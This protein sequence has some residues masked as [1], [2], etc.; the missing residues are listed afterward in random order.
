M[1][2]ILNIRRKRIAVFASGNG[3]NLQAIIDH[4]KK[5]DINGDVV[6]ALSNN[7]DAFA[8]KRAANSGIE[9]EYIPN[10][11][12]S[13]RNEF[14]SR[15]SQEIKNKN[16]DLVC[17]AGYML[18]L[19]PDFIKEYQNRILNIHPSLLPSFK[20]MHGIRDAFDYGVKVTGVTVHFVDSELDNGPIILQEAV[21]INEGETFEDLEK[22]IH[23]TEHR[24]YPQAVRYFCRE[25][26]E[27]IGKKVFIT[28]RS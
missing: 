18:L 10:S 6:L 15:I 14:D 12:N 2:E 8:L 23:E 27:I 4:T 19:S 24:L 25:E 28:E 22:K 11:M 26:L 21:L 3:S 20:G 16:I 13:S 17:L 9:T 5:N 1:P 7:K